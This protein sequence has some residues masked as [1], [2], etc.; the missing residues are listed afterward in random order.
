MGNDD[1]GSI[2]QQGFQP[3]L[4][5]SLAR[6]IER[7]SGFIKNQHSRVSNK[8]PSERHQLALSRREPA[9]AFVDIGVIPL[10]QGF[11]ELV[12]T[13][14]ARCLLNFREAC[15]GLPEADVLRHAAGEHVS[16]LGYQHDGAAQVPIDDGG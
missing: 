10:G 9:A 11:D 4:N 3:V 5:Q 14:G 16:L 6:N 2:C 12:G 1:G 13:D 7:C 8:C 15:V